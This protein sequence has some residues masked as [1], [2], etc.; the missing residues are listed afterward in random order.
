MQLFELF[1]QK[2]IILD[3]P[4]TTKDE[5]IAY[6]ANA[7]GDAG[8]VSDV[9]TYIDALHEREALS[10]TGIGEGIAIPHAKSSAV[11]EATIVF[12]R[13]LSGMDWQ[14]L[15]GAPAQLF[16]MI[17]APEGADNTHLQ[18]LAQLSKVL[19]QPTAKAA[20]L[21]A[22]DSATII[23]VF[24]R[25]GEQPTK[26]V[27]TIPTTA[28]VS[29]PEILAVTA[30][31]TGIAHTFMAEE[32]LKQAAQKAGVSIKVETNGQAGIENALTAAEIANAKTIIV[33]ADKKVET[34]RFDGKHVITV[35]VADGIYK[36]DELIEKASKQEAKIFKAE[37]S[38]SDEAAS[39]ADETIGRKFYKHLMNGVSNMLPFVI[40]G[41]IL[42][43]ISFMFGIHSADPMSAEYNTFAAALKQIGDLS[44]GVIVPILAGFIGM[45]IADRP[46]LVVGFVGGLL[47]NVGGAGF[48]GG[49][50]AGFLAGGIIIALRKGLSWLPKPFE[51]LKA[52]FLFPVLGAVIMG[53]IMIFLVNEPVAF[54]N[55]SLQSFVASMSGGNKVLLGLLLGGMMA[56]DMGGP[57]NK[58]AYVTGAALL[59]SGSEAGQE[60]MAAVMAG[61]MVPP[62]AI[63]VSV[64]VF[65]KL[66][67]QRDREA[68]YLN[69]V[70]G[71]S[72]IT[73]G[74]IPFAASNPLRVI[75]ALAIGAATTGA[76]SMFFGAASPAPHGG[77]FVFPVMTN[78]GGYIIAIVAGTLVG[79]IILSALM[80]KQ[81]SVAGGARTK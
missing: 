48:L 80:K 19:L 3:I 28:V 1:D 14:S 11:K 35:P 38:S 25:F 62:L 42:I 53:L 52:I 29:G 47:A 69:Y 79:A 74:A 17:A 66:W 61:G 12:G 21:G 54:L 24:K 23:D 2:L 9:Q 41:G 34:N 4:T 59:A 72:F 6:L 81:Q 55:E 51:G 8:R 26:S 33:A 73:E 50:L 65:P 67:S 40:A 70:M 64:T 22:T 10:S 45:S 63:A 49:L 7:L 46:G 16:F 43:A 32:K 60:V 31:P 36:A 78:V 75:P 30:C 57:I 56:I 5:T 71:A 13:K 76:L 15:D 58:A 27:E 37:H 44:F 77:I 18:A 68:G 39:T 20:L